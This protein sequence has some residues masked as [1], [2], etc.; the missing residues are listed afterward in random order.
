VRGWYAR[1][2][3]AFIINEN[4]KDRARRRLAKKKYLDAKQDPFDGNNLKGIVLA[5]MRGLMPF[6]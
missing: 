1:R 2:A 6:R 4:K 3:F 5:V